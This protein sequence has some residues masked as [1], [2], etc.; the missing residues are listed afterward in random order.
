MLRPP[1]MK[2]AIYARYSSDNQRN[3]SIEDQFRI[4]REYAKRQG[5]KIVKE[6]SDAAISG[7]TLLRLGFQAMMQ[8]ALRKEVEGVLAE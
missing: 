3:A 7:A 2:V 8:S 5:W 6:Y 1:A 4:C